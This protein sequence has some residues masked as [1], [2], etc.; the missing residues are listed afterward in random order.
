MPERLEKVK[1]MVFFLVKFSLGANGARYPIPLPLLS[2]FGYTPCLGQTFVRIRL[3]DQAC[4][5]HFLT[6]FA[7]ENSPPTSRYM[8]G[9]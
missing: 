3:A 8:S 4:R 9:S 2:P 6:S 1:S 7:T 5:I